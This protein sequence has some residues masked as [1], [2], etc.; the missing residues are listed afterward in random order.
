[1]F[2]FLPKEENKTKTLD[3]TAGM[4]DRMDG[5]NDLIVWL[6]KFDISF[7]KVAI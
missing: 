2:F 4:V 7:Y 3:A 1:M 6:F 5:Q